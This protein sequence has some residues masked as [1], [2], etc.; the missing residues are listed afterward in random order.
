[1]NAMGLVYGSVCSGIEAA[2]VAWEPLGWKPVWFSEIDPFACEVLRH[3]FGKDQDKHVQVDN[4]GDMKNLEK[5][6]RFRDTVGKIDV[7]VAGTPCPSFSIAGEREGLDDEGGQ[8]ALDFIRLARK[9]G[10]RWVV[11]ENVPGALSSQEGKN[12][13]RL[14]PKCGHSLGRDRCSACGLPT[15]DQN[16]HN[17]GA[18]LGALQDGGYQFAYRVL[19]ARYFGVPQGRRRVFVVGHLGEDW[20]PAAA[21]LFDSEGCFRG[22]SENGEGERKT[23]TR[24]QESPGT[25]GW[26]GWYSNTG[27]TVRCLSAGGI[28]RINHTAD[29]FLIDSAG[30]RVRYLTPLE[31]ERAQ[32]LPPDWTQI[33]W[34]GKPALECPHTIRFSAIGNSMAV[35]VMEWIGR[36]IDWVET[37]LRLTR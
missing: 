9:S 13:G 33:P 27:D 24:V 1:M 30:G 37:Y 26:E 12:K 8:L 3:H 22:A 19:D 31:W 4:L 32:G 36:R 16:P 23:R 35:P 5:D 20:R 17:L 34:K 10:A 25:G 15:E 28:A 21:V 14:C 6:K 29:T 11:W 2:T 18:V 7:I